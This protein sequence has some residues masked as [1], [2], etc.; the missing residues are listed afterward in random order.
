MKL[1]PSDSR[2]RW[3][4]AALGLLVAGSFSGAQAANIVNLP[5]NVEDKSG[6]EFIDIVVNIEDAPTVLDFNVGGGEEVSSTQVSI[7]LNDGARAN[8]V[9]VSWSPN[10]LDFGT[11]SPEEVWGTNGVIEG[12]IGFGRPSD[13]SGD[14]TFTATDTGTAHE[15][16]IFNIPGDANILHIV[17]DSEIFYLPGEDFEMTVNVVPIP[18]AVWL[19]GSGLIGLVGVARRKSRVS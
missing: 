11:L 17:E 3:V 19:L 18:G 9:R 14:I 12:L 16:R 15:L 5:A 4:T 13:E 8:G 7:N 1:K 2:S 6:F 10:V